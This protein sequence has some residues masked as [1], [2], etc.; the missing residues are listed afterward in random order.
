MMSRQR[1][2][3]QRQADALIELVA[4]L[5]LD[6]DK[7][8][9]RAA[10][11][12]AA[13]KAGGSYARLV[14]AAVRAAERASNVTP[15]VIAMEGPHWQTGIDVEPERPRFCE[16]CNRTHRGDCPPPEPPRYGARYP[17][18]HA[19]HIAALRAARKPMRT[20]EPE[21]TA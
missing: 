12:D 18:R 1:E 13:P 20:Y 8:G 17:D 7:R 2:I 16:R 21:E 4:C 10:L 9:I 11:S 3:D 15:A 5:R 19:D 6:W 14:V